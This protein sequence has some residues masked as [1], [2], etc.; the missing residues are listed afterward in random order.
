MKRAFFLPTALLVL[1]ILLLAGLAF[2]GTRV[3]QYRA[4]NESVW[5]SQALALAE[6]GLED[7]RIKLQKDLFF[8]PP[9]SDEQLKFSYVEEFPDPASGQQGSYEVTIDL[10]RSEAPYQV[11]RVRALGVVGSRQLALARRVLEAEYDLA[12]FDR[13][14]PTQ[15]NPNSGRFIQFVDQGSL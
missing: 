3:L 7:A 9:T 10:S 4:S 14:N 2:L 1:A 11:L 12:A 5:A 15:P 8:P 6:A 13:L